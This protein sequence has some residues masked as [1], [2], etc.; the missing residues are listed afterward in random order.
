MCYSLNIYG[1]SKHSVESLY[2][3]PNIL[4][5][6]HFSILLRLYR[7]QSITSVTF[8]IKPLVGSAICW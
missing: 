6:I 2:L 7:V 3:V 8:I 1:N 5:N 4:S